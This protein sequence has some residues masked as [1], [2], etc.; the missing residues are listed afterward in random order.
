M[1]E[2][3]KPPLACL[4]YFVTTL[5]VVA[6]PK[7]N[8]KEEIKLTSDDLS[9][10]AKCASVEKSA[11]RWQVQLSIRQMAKLEKNAPYNFR[12]TLFG[13]F[14]VI[15]AFP[16]E[17]E[18]RLVETNATSMLMGAAREVLRSAMSSGPYAPMLLPTWSF[19]HPEKT[20]PDKKDS[21]GA[22]K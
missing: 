18:E 8:R 11:R 5:A 3:L 9:V 12:L 4:G 21:E 17:H 1:S 10:T 14:E 13:L 2:L 20:A 16:A 19:Y 7:H 22:A 6:N 15:H